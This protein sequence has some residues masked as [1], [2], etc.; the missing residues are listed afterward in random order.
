MAASLAFGPEWYAET[1]LG[2]VV[3]LNA[4]AFAVLLG[5]RRLA[6][7][8]RIAAWWWLG[9]LALLG[10]IALGRIDAVTVPLALTGAALG[11]GPPAPRR[12]APDDRHVGQGVAGGPR[13]RARDRRRAS[14]G[15]CVTRRDHRSA[16]ASSPSASSPDPG[17]TPSDSSPSRPDAA[18]RSRRRWP[19]PGCGRSSRGRPPSRS[20]YDREILTFQI[21]GP[22]ADAAA[23]ADDAADG[24]RRGRRAAPRR[25]RR[26]ARRGLRTSPPAARALVRR[27]ADARQQGRITAVRD[28]ARGADHPRARPAAAPVPPAG[29]ARRGGR[30]LTHVSIPTSTAGCS[31]RIRRSCCCSPPR[32]C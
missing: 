23:A 18:C 30:A 17:S 11:G 3:L 28:L 21:A 1:W 2:I 32:S 9:F 5:D 27:G 26:A 25:P 31:R 16:S 13:R 10:P 7:T 29:G 14:A 15:R 22:G 8:R 12:R 19:S 24:A 6:R 20:C 4:A